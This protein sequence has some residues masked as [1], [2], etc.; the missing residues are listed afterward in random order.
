MQSP[1]ITTTSSS[2]AQ[3]RGP[4]ILSTITARLRHARG[5]SEIT[6]GNSVGLRPARERVRLALPPVL[7]ISLLS[8][9]H[10]TARLLRPLAPAR[11]G[12]GLIIQPGH[13]AAERL[14]TR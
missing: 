5:A 6:S 10:R 9:I 7:P 13:I 8:S 1:P 4:A 2:G 14:P 3:S 12:H 11:Y